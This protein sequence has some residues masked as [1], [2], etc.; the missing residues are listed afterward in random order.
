MTLEKY[1]LGIGDR[2]G[3]EGVAQ[4]R[5]LQKAAEHGVAVVPVWNKSHREHSIIGTD[6]EDTLRAAAAA[7]HAAAWTKP[8]YLDADHI[9]LATLD[10]FIVPCNFFTIDVADVIGRAA[11]R[12]SASA[13]LKAVR[14]FR[15]TLAIPG[16]RAPITVDDALLQAVADKYLLAVIEAG[17]V[18]RRIIANRDGQSFVVEMSLDE[19]DFP[20]S[21]AELF[22]I[23]AAAAREGIPLQTIAPKFTGDFLKGIDYV[24]DISRFESEFRD[25]LAVVNRAITEFSL[26]V[27]LKLSVH[28]G[29]DKFSLYPV[30]R[31]AIRDFDA[32]L[33]LKTAGTTWLEEVIGIAGHG[34]EALLLAKELY[35]L[36]FTRYDELCKPY[37]TVVRIDR[38]HLP[39][40]AEVELWTAVQYVE[41]LRHDQ[42][43]PGYNKDFRQFVHVSFRIAAEMGERYLAMLRECRSTIEQNVTS[44]LYDR[45]LKPLFVG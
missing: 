36:A 40:P 3:M 25:H 28:T 35:A 34:G 20:Q 7:V 19:A 26:P 2:F 41:A 16:M 15:G 13:F 18:Y 8:F 17:K 4:L 21:P 30:I 38:S 44:N 32:G 24:G 10:K 9:G 33:H 27:N 42:T 45:H 22:F 31:S 5:A 11:D 43:C 39:D 12:R 37:A 6:P 23:L 14:P 29:S 1:S